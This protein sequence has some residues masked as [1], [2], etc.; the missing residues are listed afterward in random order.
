MNR[1]KSYVRRTML[2][3]ARDYA[4][5]KRRTADST[6]AACIDAMRGTDSGWWADLIYTAPMLDMAHNYRRDIA[7]AFAEYRD[8]TGDRYTFR[9]SSTGTETDADE[10]LSA[11]LRGPFDF[12]DYRGMNGDDADATLLGLRFAVEWYAGQTARDICPDI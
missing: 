9:D 6:R 5:G 8:E 11:L 4:G 3:S 2:Q 10:I 1:L 7:T 12:E